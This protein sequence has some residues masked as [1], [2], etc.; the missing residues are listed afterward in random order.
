MMLASGSARASDG[1]RGQLRDRPPRD[2]LIGYERVI[3]V[4][5]SGY[6]RGAGPPEEPRRSIA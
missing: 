1:S 3:A 6:G 5:T 2:P 4:I